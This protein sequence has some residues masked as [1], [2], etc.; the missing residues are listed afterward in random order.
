MEIQLTQGMVAHI[1]DEDW[2]LVSPYRWHAELDRSTG[3]YYA[4]NKSIA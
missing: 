2:P 1:D 4:Y 3:H